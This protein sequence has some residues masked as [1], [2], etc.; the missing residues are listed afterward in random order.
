MDFWISCSVTNE[1]V[2]TWDE[3]SIQFRSFETPRNGFI[4]SLHIHSSLPH[5][6]FI[7]NL[8]I[9][10]RTCNVT[11]HPSNP[12]FFFDKLRGRFNMSRI[13]SS[14]I[15]SSQPGKIFSLLGKGITLPLSSHSYYAQTATRLLLPPLLL[16][17]T[18][19]SREPGIS[20][21]ENHLSPHHPNMY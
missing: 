8:K 1:N 16:G 10:S 15:S 20:C 17:R 7:T 6:Y 13:H 5:I 18:S 2:N 12:N 11:P 3:F 9:S 4:V 19:K 14:S 21:G